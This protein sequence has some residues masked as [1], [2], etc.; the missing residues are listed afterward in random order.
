MAT[1]PMANNNYLA[2]PLV[3]EKTPHGLDTY[4]AGAEEGNANMSCC[5]DMQPGPATP[6]IP[7]PN[8]GGQD[9]M[10]DVGGPH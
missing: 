6:S 10:M 7:V 5:A 2:M 4:G 1:D 8:L 3:G 9:C